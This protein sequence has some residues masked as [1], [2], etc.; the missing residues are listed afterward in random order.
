MLL[1]KCEFSIKKTKF[2][3]F[4]ISSKKVS[5]DSEKVQVIRD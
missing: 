4:I 2:L 3:D 5:V 1:K